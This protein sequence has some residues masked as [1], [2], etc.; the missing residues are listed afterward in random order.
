MSSKTSFHTTPHQSYQER[1]AKTTKRNIHQFLFLSG[2]VR[3]VQ[4]N[5]V[6]GILIKITNIKYMGSPN[7]KFDLWNQICDT[8]IYLSQDQTFLSEINVPYFIKF[9]KYSLSPIYRVNIAKLSPSSS[10]AGL[11]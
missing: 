3:L 10:S 11:S 9:T 5:R 8:T 6:W 4:S 1:N 7:I 2:G